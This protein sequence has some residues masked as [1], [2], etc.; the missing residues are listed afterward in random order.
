MERIP[1]EK[2]E[3]MLGNVRATL[4]IEGLLMPEEE[5]EILR[6]YLKGE[7]TEGQVLEIIRTT[8][9]ERAKD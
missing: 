3:L 8:G 7:L 1:N 5:T 9:T 4:E 6:Q 2:I